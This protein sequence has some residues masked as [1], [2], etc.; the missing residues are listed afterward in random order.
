MNEKLAYLI[1]VFFGDGCITRY[2]SR[3]FE[4]FKFVL[5]SIDRDF[6]EYT[7]ECIKSL[8]GFK[9]KILTVNQKK[10][11]ILY[12]LTI[13]NNDLFGWMKELTKKKTVIP[14]MIKSI[15]EYSREFLS[16]FMDSEGWC[17][18][19]RSKIPYRYRVGFCGSADWIDEI[20][21]MLDKSG[22]KIG[23]RQTRRSEWSKKDNVL[24]MINT[25]SFIESGIGFKIQ[26]K[27]N[28]LETYKKL[29][30]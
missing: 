29:Y 5:R 26:R 25:R 27:Q 30:M 18:E 21:R 11:R 23:K 20:I 13:G 1:G 17:A 2:E 12:Y 16:G 24:F 14:E 4:W 22:V 3:G 7:A 19:D 6:V 15:P 9:P 28:R 8:I 10:N